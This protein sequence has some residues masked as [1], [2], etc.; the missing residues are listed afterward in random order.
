MS[1]RDTP[2][3]TALGCGC[4]VL[5]GLVLLTFAGMT[6]MSYRA[7]DEFRTALLDPEARAEK[8]REVLPYRD[9]PAGY[10]PWGSLSVPVLL[11]TAMLGSREPTVQDSQ[12]GDQEPEIGERGFIYVN[13]RTPFFQAGDAQGALTDQE[14]GG[15]STLK[16]ANIEVRTSEVLR[17]GTVE[18]GG[19]ELAYTV[20][21]GTV[22]TGKTGRPALA[23]MIR[24]DCPQDD[25]LRMGLWFIPDP[26]PREKP[27]G[28]A[29]AGTPA[30]PEAIRAFAGHFRF[31]PEAAR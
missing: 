11:Q 2:R 8:T 28:A 9:L 10:H 23:A 19:R 17:E 25:R 15:A 26:A 27:E 31:C 29:F 5:I 16:T 13:T 22:T 20:H 7:G 12:A 1:V 4:G 30:D 24:V 14:S 21:R 3:R 18:V 6:R